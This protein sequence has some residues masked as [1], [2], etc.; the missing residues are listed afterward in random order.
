MATLAISGLSRV[1]PGASTPALDD[2]TLHVDDGETLVLV[3][4]S[5]CGKSTLLRLVAGLDRGRSVRVQ[6]V[7]L[8]VEHVFGFVGD[9]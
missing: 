4:P 1:H 2:V 8:L 9:A 6:R 7:S 5:G 3:G